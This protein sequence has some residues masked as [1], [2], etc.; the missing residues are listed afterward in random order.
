MEILMK[1][2][3][4][5][6]S[7]AGIIICLEILYACTIGLILTKRKKNKAIK[8]IQEL[9]EE[10]MK[11]I[12]AETSKEKENKTNMNTTVTTKKPDTFTYTGTKNSTKRVRN[13]KKS[14]E[15]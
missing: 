4:I 14:E 3:L 6:A 9:A 7:I 11:E 12:V 2:F 15:K 1:I 5:V 10:C 13:T 8:E